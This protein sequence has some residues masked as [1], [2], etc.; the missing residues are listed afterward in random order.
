MLWSQNPSSVVW[1][2]HF[3]QRVK[4]VVC[5]CAVLNVRGH[6]RVL[7]TEL[8]S[9]QSLSLYGIPTV[10]TQIAASETARASWTLGSRQAQLLV[11]SHSSRNLGGAKLPSLGSA[12][13]FYVTLGF[14]CCD[15]IIILCIL[16]A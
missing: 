10:E 5:Y 4:V 8:E 7:L 12:P 14:K 1:P 16:C 6:G 15:L 2:D 13:S 9:K 11:E 3:L